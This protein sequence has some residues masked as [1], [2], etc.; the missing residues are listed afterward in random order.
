MKAEYDFSQGR[1]GQ[2]FRPDA[3]FNL[4]EQPAA[5][6]P[7]PVHPDEPVVFAAPRCSEARLAV[8]ATG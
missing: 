6:R 5:S 1:R 3:R 7:E 4:P 8:H 2:F